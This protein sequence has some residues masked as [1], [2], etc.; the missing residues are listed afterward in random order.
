MLGAPV[1][2][3]VGR[4]ALRARRRGRAGDAGSSARCRASS[5]RTWTTFRPRV[6][7]L[8]NLEPDHLDRHGSFEA[9]RDAKLRDVR[10]PARGRHRRRPAR[11][12]RRSGTRGASSSPPTTRCPPS[13]C[14]P[15]A[16]NRENAAAATAA[17]RAAGHR[18]TRDRGGAADVPGRRRTGS[19]PS[20][21]STACAT[22]TTRRR[23]TSPRRAAAIAAYDAPLHA[24]PRR[25]AQGRGLRAARRGA[26]RRTCAR[27]YLIGETADELTPRSTSPASERGG[28]LATRRALRPRATPRPATS[29]CSRRPAR[30]TTSSTNFEERG[31]RVPPARRGSAG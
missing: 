4:G 6:A 16:H 13:R 17:A 11:V 15:G 22:S 26:R 2:G 8:L 1:A 14:I 29:F 24:D 21:R 19:S 9:Y 30:A 7:V 31:E 5:S 12:R 23:R 3:N 18:R 25:L 20:A 10:E 27:V 28:D